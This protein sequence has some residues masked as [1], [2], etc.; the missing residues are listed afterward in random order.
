M[1]L[2]R[3][4]SLDWSSDHNFF[5]IHLLPLRTSLVRRVTIAYERLAIEKQYQQLDTELGLDHF[6]GR[7]HTG[8]NCHVALTAVAYA[9]LRREA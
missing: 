4:S 3:E 2:Q 7:T 8:W 6:E 9:F 5:L 1:R